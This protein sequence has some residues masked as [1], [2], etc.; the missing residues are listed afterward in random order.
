MH[1]QKLFFI[2][3]IVIIC[4]LALLISCK[5]NGG[6]QDYP[7]PTPNYIP[8]LVDPPSA[9]STGPQNYA[10]TY[11]PNKVSR[12]DYPVPVDNF[13]NPGFNQPVSGPRPPPSGPVPGVSSY[14]Q[15][16]AGSR[17]QN[18]MAVSLSTSHPT[19]NTFPTPQ[20]VGNAKINPPATSQPYDY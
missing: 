13:G 18:P 2:L 12:I 9:G 5:R 10:T 20:P 14:S 3:I 11:F 7:K 8:Y 4:V 16:G 6:G 19:S 15:P 1:N 17:L